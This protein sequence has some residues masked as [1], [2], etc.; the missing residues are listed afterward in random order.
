MG[1]D[2]IFLDMGGTFIDETA[3]WEDRIQR[4]AEVNGIS[5]EKFRKEMELAAK[6]NLPEY[7]TAMQKF[8]IRYMEPFN[9]SLERLYPNTTEALEMLRKRYRLG[10]IANQSKAAREQLDSFGVLNYFEHLTISGEIW[11]SKPSPTIF[12]ET[13]RLAGTTAERCIMVGDKLTN[14]IKPAK[15]LG[16]R[17][18]WIRQE[19][20][21]MQTISDEAMQPDSIA[22]SILQAAEMLLNL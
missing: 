9:H 21:G 1:K 12:R 7:Y 15:A 20:G 2:W 14:D 13:L 19:W 10:I 4:T 22:D 6:N 16:F 8:G 5:P 11:F 17:T 18:L 3:A